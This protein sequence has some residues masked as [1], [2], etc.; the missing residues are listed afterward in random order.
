MCS[1]NSEFVGEG[2]GGLYCTEFE[3]GGL[4]AYCDFDANSAIAW[5]RRQRVEV[6]SCRFA[7]VVQG[8]KFVGIVVVVVCGE[9]KN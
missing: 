1:E 4:C 5:I 6:E 7:F 3:G 8:C 2:L 9:E